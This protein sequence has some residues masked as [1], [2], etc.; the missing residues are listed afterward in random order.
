MF[1]IDK[2]QIWLLWNSKQ[3]FR[4]GPHKTIV[5]GMIDI[6]GQKSKQTSMFLS[7][8]GFI[9]RFACG[10]FFK[11]DIL[12]LSKIVTLLGTSFKTHLNLVVGCIVSAHSEKVLIWI[13]VG[14][15]TIK[16]I[17]SKNKTKCMLC[18]LLVCYDLI[19]SSVS[20]LYTPAILMSSSTTSLLVLFYA[21]FLTAQT[22]A[23][24]YRCIH[25]SSEHPSTIAMW[26]R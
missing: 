18:F 24:F 6:K 17:D 7:Q 20:L 8:F 4:H 9:N 2:C 23:S 3:N 11:I 15:W 16:F 13:P 22:S 21:F 26:I 1:C 5:W 19:I 10:F 25:C 12:D 14:T